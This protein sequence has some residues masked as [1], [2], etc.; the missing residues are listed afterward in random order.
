[1]LL[2]NTMNIHVYIYFSKTLYNSQHIQCV[3]LLDY[4]SYASSDT[5]SIIHTIMYTDS[6]FLIVI[7]LLW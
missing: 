7:S 3:V 4:Y 6:W 1:M 5:F 2:K